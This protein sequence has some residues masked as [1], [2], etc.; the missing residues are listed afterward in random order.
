M[1]VL[2]DMDSYEPTAFAWEVIS[3]HL[4]PGDVICLD[5]AGIQDERR[6]LNE[7]VLPLISCEPVGTRSLGL[8]LVVTR[9]VP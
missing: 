3:P 1:F 5:D 8:G 4:R 9:P 7:R 2:F 6:V